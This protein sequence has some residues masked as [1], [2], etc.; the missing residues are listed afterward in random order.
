MSL[1][2]EGLPPDRDLFPKDQPTRRDPLID[3]AQSAMS[4]REAPARLSSED[5]D[6]LREVH[7]WLAEIMPAVRVAMKMLEAKSKIMSWGFGGKR[8]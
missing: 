8:N 4:G 7:E 6:K 2:S 3:D 5:I 1:F